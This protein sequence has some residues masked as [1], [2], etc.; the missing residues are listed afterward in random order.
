MFAVGVFAVLSRAPGSFCAVPGPT[1]GA[2][3]CDLTL[4]DPQLASLSIWA[5]VALLRAG[6]T[7]GEVFGLLSVGSLRR[8]V[9]PES[10]RES[11]MNRDWNWSDFG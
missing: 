3:F 8:R 7:N 6:I 10:L 4:S 1:A 5:V 2:V 9:V 11:G